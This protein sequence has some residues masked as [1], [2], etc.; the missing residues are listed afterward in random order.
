[1]YEFQVLAGFQSSSIFPQ[2]PTTYKKGEPE[3]LNNN[4]TTKS[5]ENAG[6]PL[7][8]S[9]KKLGDS[10]DNSDSGES[11]GTPS[12]TLS[13]ASSDS[14]VTADSTELCKE[15]N[16]SRPGRQARRRARKD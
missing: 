11:S 14:G 6:L 12:G 1:M 16:T 2:V 8:Q 10:E 5:Q 13:E 4:Y 15:K 9:T 3:R 7:K